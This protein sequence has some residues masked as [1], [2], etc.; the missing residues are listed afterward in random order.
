MDGKT[1][2]FGAVGAVG[3]TAGRVPF[4][5]CLS[6]IECVQGIK[7]PIAAANAVLYYSRHLDALGRIPP[8]W[9]TELMKVSKPR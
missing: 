5:L 3:G 7:N 2:D 9:G 1:N 4:P 8:M 6:T